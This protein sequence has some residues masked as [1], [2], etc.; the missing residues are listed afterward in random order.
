MKLARGNTY[1]YPIMFYMDRCFAGVGLTPSIIASCLISD[2][3]DVATG[4]K[5]SDETTTDTGTD[6]EVEHEQCDRTYPSVHFDLP[7]PAKEAANTVID[8]GVYETS[9]SS[10]SHR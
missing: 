9:E 4:T 5:P 3:S 6:P 7:E 10:F 1:T 8:D 2:G